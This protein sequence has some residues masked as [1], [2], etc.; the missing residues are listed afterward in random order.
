MSPR[1]RRRRWRRRRQRCEEDLFDDPAARAALAAR[2]HRLV[3]ATHDEDIHAKL[4]SLFRD[5]AAAPGWSWTPAADR[6]GR[7][8]WQCEDTIESRALQRDP[9]CLAATLWGPIYFR[10]GMLVYTNDNTE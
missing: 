10:D 7:Y 4:L 2:A 8:S 9:K 5:P 6:A 3:I 1:A